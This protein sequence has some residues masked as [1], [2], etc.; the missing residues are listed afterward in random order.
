MDEE[1]M[2]KVSQRGQ[3][4]YTDMQ[5][6]HNVFLP[7]QSGIPN[8]STLNLVKNTT[9]ATKNFGQFFQQHLPKLGKF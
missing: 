5:E 2:Y 6:C 1:N 4:G 8:F 7:I 9:V 3:S